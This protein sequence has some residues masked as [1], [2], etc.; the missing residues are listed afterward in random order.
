MS[1]KQDRP[2][3]ETTSQ[4]SEMQKKSALTWHAMVTEPVSIRYKIFKTSG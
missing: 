4:A 3:G 2:Y 1:T